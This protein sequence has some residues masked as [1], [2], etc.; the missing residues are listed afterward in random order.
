MIIPVSQALAIAQSYFNSILQH[1]DSLMISPWREAALGDPVLVRTVES[2]PS[3]WI[4]PVERP[5]Q[6]LGHI[7]IG[8]DGRV[9]GYAYLYQN[10]ANLSVCPPLATRISAEEARELANDLLKNY[11]GARFS[12]PVFV[13]DGPHS[14]LAWMIEVRVED[15]LVSR[16][17]VTPGYAYERRIGEEPPP[18]GW[19]GGSS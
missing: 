15:E 9:M 19:R 14:R 5:G 7:N 6:V 1:D 16:V 2:R 4:I 10:P 18:P 12:T 8:P 3:F 11:R 17:F 13:H